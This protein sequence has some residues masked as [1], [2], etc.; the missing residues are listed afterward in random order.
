MLC[1]CKVF[2]KAGNIQLFSFYT[3]KYLRTAKAE[4]LDIRQNQCYFRFAL[5]RNATLKIR[6]STMRKEEKPMTNR[7]IVDRCLNTDYTRFNLNIEFSSPYNFVR[8]LRE[9]GATWNA[10]S[11]KEKVLVRGIFKTP[12][13]AELNMRAYSLKIKKGRAF[14]WADIEPA[15]LEVLKDICGQDAEITIQ[16]FRTAIDK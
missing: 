14:H 6:V 15:I 10:L 9:K 12:G 13:V 4:K 7:I 11:A 2:K 5:V 3:L 1:S 16:D 8:P